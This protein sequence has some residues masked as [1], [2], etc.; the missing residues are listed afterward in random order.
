L[1]ECNK[2]TMLQLNEKIE[3]GLRSTMSYAGV[4]DVYSLRNMEAR[5]KL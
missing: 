2:L 1:I 3:Q 4:D 5:Q